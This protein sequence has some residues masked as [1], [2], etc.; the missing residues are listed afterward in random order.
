MLKRAPINFVIQEL[1][2]AAVTAKEQNDPAAAAAFSE[3]AKHLYRYADDPGTGFSGIRIDVKEIDQNQEHIRWLVL[4]PR[5]VYSAGQTILLDNNS[6]GDIM[7][8][9]DGILIKGSIAT[10]PITAL[11]I[12]GFAK[13][14]NMGRGDVFGNREF[15]F[16]MA[17]ANHITGT[18]LKVDVGPSK[19]AEVARKAKSW[20]KLI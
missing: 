1:T 6:H 8:T 18:H 13:D 5:T 7:I 4:R 17:V 11:L 9:R 2:R 16:N 20:E 12:A 15:E 3:R 10:K 19:A 14:Y